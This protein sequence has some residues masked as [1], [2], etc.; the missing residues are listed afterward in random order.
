MTTPKL[1]H[2][3][4]FGRL[5][6]R[7]ETPVSSLKP[8]LAA[9]E[10]GLLMPSVTNVIDVLNKPF[11]QTWYA[12][13][14]AEDA[15]KVNTTHPGLMESKPQEAIKWIA[16]AASRTANSAAELGDK[17]HEAVE[18]LANGE[19]PEIT[20]DIRGHVRS[21]ERFITDQK[22][23]FKFLEATAYGKTPEGLTYAGTADFIAEINGKLYVGD[24]KTG[25]SIHTEAALQ[26][27]ALAHA[28]E[29]YDEVLE[30]MLPMPKI[31]G[32]LVVHL[33]ANG[34][35]LHIVEDLTKPYEVFSQLR[36]VWDFYSENSATRIPLFLEKKA[37]L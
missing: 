20:A 16:A 14:A 35:N 25:K 23:T 1:A 9:L 28:A 15:I 36:T 19:E 8:H 13:R 27:S 21:W 33:T 10:S 30:Q 32:G 37:N 2:S 34:Y 17:V 7:P 11:L 26:L 18:V 29:L 31:N 24:Y 22:P 5:Y 4:K 12:K 6:Q 3:T